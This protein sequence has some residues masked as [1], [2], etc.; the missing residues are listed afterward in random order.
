MRQ[1]VVL[2]DAS[3]ASAAMELAE[4]MGIPDFKA[5]QHWILRFKKRHGIREFV[6]HGEAAA[7]DTQKAEEAQ[8]LV[9]EFMELKASF[10]AK[11]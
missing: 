11:A 5:S 9:P 1:R 2:G 6:K 4:S 7:A 3:V 10:Y 8:R